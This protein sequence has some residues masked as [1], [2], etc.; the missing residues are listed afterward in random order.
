MS[1][2]LTNGLCR[3]R[4]ALAGRLRSY[5]GT[6]DLLQL[7]RRHQLTQTDAQLQLAVG[8]VVTQ[9]RFDC[10]DVQRVVVANVVQHTEVFPLDELGGQEIRGPLDRWRFVRW[11]ALRQ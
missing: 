6:G 7:G 10:V 4:D 1:H 5:L 9:I 8:L 3:S 11:C 2:N